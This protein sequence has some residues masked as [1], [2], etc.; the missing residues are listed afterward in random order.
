MTTPDGSGPSEFNPPMFT[1]ARATTDS[2]EL[3]WSADRE[4]HHYNV[5][6]AMDGFPDSQFEVGGGRAGYAK[7]A[8]LTPS[9][10][11]RVRVESCDR[12]FW[13]DSTC[14]AWTPYARLSTLA[15]PPPRPPARRPQ[16]HSGFLIQSSSGWQGNF[17]LVTPT[18]G[19]FNHF[20][21]NSDQRGNGPQWHGPAFVPAPPVGPD[22]PPLQ[23]VALSLIESNWGNLEVIAAVRSADTR[24]GDNATL[25]H[26]V[27]ERGVWSSWLVVADGKP[28][29]DVVGP[30]ALIQGHFGTRGNF[31]LL[32]PV[33]SGL[34]H[35][36]RDND[37]PG[38]PWH[39]PIPVS[40]AGGGLH[41]RTHVCVAALIETK[42]G[43]LEAG[44]VQRSVLDDHA[45]LL[46]YVRG[47]Q[48]WEAFEILPD[49]QDLGAV[50]GQPGL[51]QS[52]FG[53]KG[54][55]EVVVPQMG[56]LTHIWRASDD[57]G[58]PWH[59]GARGWGD[60]PVAATLVESNYWEHG[61]LEVVALHNVGPVKSA[62]ELFLSQQGQWQ[63]EPLNPDGAP[64]TAGPFP[65][66]ALPDARQD[67]WRWCSKCQGL[68]FAG[69]SGGVCPAGEA[70]DGAGSGDY[71][72]FGNDGTAAGQ[73]NW[74]WCNKCQGLFFAGTDNG[75]CPAGN[76]HDPSASGDYL[77]FSTA[78]HF[79]G[80]DN[81]RWCR[82]CDGLF[83]AGMSAGV[84][85]F[86][87]K[88]DGSASGDYVLS[89]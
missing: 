27:R 54:N 65:F 85:P 68:F 76:R 67:N 22:D 72:L 44:A 50:I 6:W 52:S 40:G 56:G 86:A 63:Q 15:I 46:H 89:G 20:W 59:F 75:F 71:V 2:I 88:H 14:S 19:G 83:F 64:L 70:H 77:L 42:D 26:Y 73:A 38:F 31:E 13:G 5:A 66:D 45:R 49:G 62:T 17:E 78:D 4:Y 8:N 82:V 32:V 33:S 21:R 57:P 30:P 11:Y 7:L 55:L 25:Y 37:A 41:L 61:P 79:S 9:R 29:T 24:G 84:C 80:Q 69:M 47:A 34:V 28:V 48:G 87:G 39:G 53:V 23:P 35:F 43:A 16:T 12:S 3:W 81:W 51:V 60:G 10:N 1:Q 36:W 74:R 58:Q 18:P